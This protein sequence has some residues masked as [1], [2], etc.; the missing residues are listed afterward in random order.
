MIDF[1]VFHTAINI[2][3]ALRIREDLNMEMKKTV[4]DG[5]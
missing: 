4:V 1:L 2:F 5:K 3:E